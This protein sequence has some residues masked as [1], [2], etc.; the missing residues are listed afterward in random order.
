MT[1]FVTDDP[2]EPLMKESKFDNQETS[3]LSAEEELM[4]SHW[5]SQSRSDKFSQGFPGDCLNI[6][7]L[8]KGNKRCVDCQEFDIFNGISVEPMYAS[9]SYGTLICGE[10][11]KVHTKRKK[12]VS[13]HR[14]WKKVVANVGISILSLF[15]SHILFVVSYRKTGLLMK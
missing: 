14:L 11:V 5:I 13:L 9:V 2:D 10:C 15:L 3:M 12:L 7:R 8:M 4:E 6:V 1:S